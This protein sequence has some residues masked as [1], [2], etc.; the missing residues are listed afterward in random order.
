MPSD[1]LLTLFG[2]FRGVRGHF[3][4]IFLGMTPN[5]PFDIFLTFE[6]ISGNMALQHT[7]PIT[8]IKRNR[9]SSNALAHGTGGLRGKIVGFRL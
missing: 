6:A 9:T 1:I 5:R 8:G 2:Q 4:D 3:F 7:L